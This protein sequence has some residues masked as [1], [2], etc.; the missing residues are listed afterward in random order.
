MAIR[1]K[2]QEKVEEIQ[3]KY[4]M[5]KDG[6]S[7]WGIGLYRNGEIPIETNEDVHKD[8]LTIADKVDWYN[9]EVARLAEVNA[10]IKVKK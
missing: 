3:A 5:Y 1:I 9:K 7:Y 4:N 10:E 8:S 6:S 2:Q